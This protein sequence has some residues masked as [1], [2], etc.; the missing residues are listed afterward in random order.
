MNDLII[1]PMEA[2]SGD[3]ELGCWNS[4]SGWLVEYKGVEYDDLVPWATCTSNSDVSLA[5]L[6]N[7]V[8]RLADGEPVNIV[9]KDEVCI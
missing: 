8:I 6:L 5:D 9:I 7:L 3:C 4:A 1:T 2:D